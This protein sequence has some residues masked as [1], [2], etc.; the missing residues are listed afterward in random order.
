M[1]VRAKKEVREFITEMVRD[2]G[3]EYLGRAR[4]NHHLLLLPSGRKFIVPSSPSD[5]R[6]M[7]NAR[8]VIR[9]SI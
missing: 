1:K 8:A 3:V 6:W 9:R 2:Y 5:H 7:R 4:N